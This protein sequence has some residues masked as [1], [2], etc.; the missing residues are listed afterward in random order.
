[1]LPNTAQENIEQN[2]K[3]VKRRNRNFGLNIR[4]IGGGF[5]RLILIDTNKEGERLFISVDLYLYS[6]DTNFSFPKLYEDEVHDRILT[7]G[8]YIYRLWGD[9]ILHFSP[10]MK[11]K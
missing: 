6:R 7:I 11:R 2:Q 3:R 8:P 4:K 5:Q 10:L 9:P 1:M